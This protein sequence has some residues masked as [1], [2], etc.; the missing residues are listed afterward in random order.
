MTNPEKFFII[1]VIVVVTALSFLNMKKEV[2][3]SHFKDWTEIP[4]YMILGDP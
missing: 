2:N 1:M 3:E 4:S